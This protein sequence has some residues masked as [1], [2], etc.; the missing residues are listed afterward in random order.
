MPNE[1]PQFVRPETTPLYPSSV[2]TFPSLDALRAHYDGDESSFLYRRNGNPNNNAVEALISKLEQT[3]STVLCAS[4]MAAISQSCMAMLRPGDHLLATE[5]LY[6]GSYVFFEQILRSWG[7]DVSYVN[8]NDL[9]ATAAAV[10]PNTRLIYVETIANPLLQVADLEQ[11]SRFA[12]A[13]GIPWMV[14]NTFATPF[15]TC[16]TKLGAS[17]VIHSLTKYLNGHSDV[18]GGSC[19]GPATL[20]EQIRQ[21]AVSFGGVLSPFD[22]WMTERGLKT[23]ALRMRQQCDNASTVAEFLSQHPAVAKVFYPGL[24]Q[25]PTH[26]IA[27]RVLAGRYGAMVTFEIRGTEATVD[28]FVRSCKAIHL[29]PSLGGLQTTLSHPA[30]TSHRAFSE[31]ARASQGITDAVIRVSV[32][33]E[34]I[35][36]ILADFQQALTLA[37]SSS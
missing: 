32:G 20:I 25:H 7:V 2:Y 37:V 18:M 9:E 10:R 14:D 5:V 28:K 27:N 36:D 15:L 11:I 6:G 1:V 3:E 16:P 19:S 4:G 35:D 26:D 34:P 31:E 21:F 30:L 33:A 8:L 29:A 23:F 22:A 13:H 24:R 12:Q 17:V